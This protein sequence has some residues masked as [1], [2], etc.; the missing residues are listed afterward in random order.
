MRQHYKKNGSNREF[1][2]AGCSHDCNMTINVATKFA[3]YSKCSLIDNKELYIIPT[4]K[5]FHEIDK[6]LIDTFKNYYH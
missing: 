6:F 2:F 4:I 5:I 1:A 3:T